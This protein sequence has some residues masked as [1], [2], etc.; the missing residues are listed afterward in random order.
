[1]QPS[2]ALNNPVLIRGSGKKP[3]RAGRH[4]LHDL[5]RGGNV[6]DQIYDLAGN[7]RSRVKIARSTRGR[8]ARRFFILMLQQV[9]FTTTPF[10]GKIILENA[11]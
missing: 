1:M 4:P 2:L 5:S 3:C 10:L 6:G 8:I 9:S 7:D 11:A